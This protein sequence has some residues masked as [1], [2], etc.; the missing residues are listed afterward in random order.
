MLINTVDS[1]FVERNLSAKSE[2]P[3]ITTKCSKKHMHMHNGMLY[4][5]TFNASYSKKEQSTFVQ[6]TE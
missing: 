5:L 6:S 1:C 3:C 2:I 4:I